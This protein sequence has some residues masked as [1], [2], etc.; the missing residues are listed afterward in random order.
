MYLILLLVVFAITG[1]FA[2]QNDQTQTFTLL[3]YSWNVPLWTPAVIG[4]GV[5]AA[6]LMLHMSHAGMG[7]RLRSMGQD[8]MLDEHRGRLDD[9]RTENAGLREELAAAR[10]EV[11]GATRVTTGRSWMDG[12]RTFPSRFSRRSST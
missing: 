7:S 6:L 4:V 8:R 1:L 12:I 9:L 10:G 11:R 5:V 3:S 2:V